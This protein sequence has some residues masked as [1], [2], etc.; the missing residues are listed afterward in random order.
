MNKPNPINYGELTDDELLSLL[1]NKDETAFDCIYGKYHRQLF[2][3][4]MKLV[5]NEHDAS[6]IVQE[7]FVRMWERSGMMPE[8]LNLKAYMI[9]AVRNRVLNYIR[10]SKSRFLNNYRIVQETEHSVDNGAFMGSEHSYRIRQLERAI[11]ALPP[12]Q[13][14]VA[15]SRRKGYSNREIAEMLNLS[16]NTVNIHY[17]LGLKTMKEKMKK[18]Y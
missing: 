13:K 12:Q 16:L 1:K 17:R 10:D 9:S 3:F 5:K 18:T 4:A 2:A 15:E 11:E 8:H 7:V 6:D 14:K